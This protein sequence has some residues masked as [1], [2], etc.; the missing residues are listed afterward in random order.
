M[1]NTFFWLVA[2]NGYVRLF[3]AKGICKSALS[4]YKP[5]EILGAGIYT[6]KS[7]PYGRGTIVY[8]RCALGTKW[9]KAT[10]LASGQIALHLGKT[11]TKH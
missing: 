8:V 2:D 4:N 3:S 7:G 1:E 6:L 9:G 5:T 10:K 11:A